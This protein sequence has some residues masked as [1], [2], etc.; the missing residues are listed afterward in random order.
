MVTLMDGGSSCNQAGPARLVMGVRAPDAL[1]LS[2]QI[3]HPLLL[4]EI[5]LKALPF[6]HEFRPPDPLF[7]MEQGPFGLKSLHSLLTSLCKNGVCAPHNL[8]LYQAEIKGK[9]DISDVVVEV[10]TK[11]KSQRYNVVQIE[12]MQQRT[13][14]QQG[15]TRNS[16]GRV[17]E[18]ERKG[19]EALSSWKILRP[20]SNVDF[21]SFEE[22][23]HPSTPNWTK[24]HAIVMM[25]SVQQ[26]EK[27][28]QCMQYADII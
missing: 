20:F 10:G 3:L 26:L 24:G 4:M 22:N 2:P 7:L 21:F 23:D 12:C 28:L 19:K 13:I 15:P 5:G 25:S 11:A 1:S 27:V 14:V 8:G 16:D 17:K 6:L 9:K 18:N